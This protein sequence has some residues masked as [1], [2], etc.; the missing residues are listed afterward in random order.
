VTNE[1]MRCKRA[2]ILGERVM[3]MR[4]STSI[5]NGSLSGEEILGRLS[6]MGGSRDLHSWLTR[7]LRMILLVTLVV[8]ALSLTTLLA[9]E[10]QVFALK[11]FLVTFL[12]LL[13]GWLYLQFIRLK[14]TGLYDEYVLN[15]Y[16]LKIDEIGNLPKPP[17]GSSYRDQWSEA[18]GKA[19]DMQISR[20]VYL[21]RFESIYGRSAVP[22]SRRQRDNDGNA[23]IEGPRIVE[24]LKQDAFSPVMWTTFLVAVGWIVVIQPELFSGLE[25][26]GPMTISGLPA[27]PV[28][29]LRFGFI[30]AYVFI[31]H[32]LVRR[33]FQADLKTHAYVAAVARIVVVAALLVTVGPV[34]EEQPLAVTSSFAFLVGMFPELGIRLIKQAAS[35]LGRKLTR[36]PEEDRYPVTDLDGLNLWSRARLFEEGIEDMQNLTTA[37]LPDLLLN[38]RMPIN[39][40]LDWI[41]QSF[42]YMRVGSKER[43][44]L[45]RLGIR[46]ASDLIDAFETKDGQDPS[47][48]GRLLRL[49]NMR[50]R[51]D[52]DGPSVT[53]GL[54]IA[55]LGEVNLWHIRQWKKHGWLVA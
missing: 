23:A 8:A 43:M 39:R 54:R 16:R 41:D 10:Y 50:G 14:G 34:L 51:K 44:V 17:P 24:Q 11:S 2:R 25:P 13:P 37:N 36:L 7:T 9:R 1:N 4:N 33:Y 53:E 38:T 27:I 15:L 46:T 29:V 18:V 30:G 6:S 20:N 49:L 55:L 47:F 48:K 42:L 40:L 26:F 32:G 45:R 19:D 22:Q 35:A 12:A 3:A 21:K 52:D 28:D 5:V 31:L